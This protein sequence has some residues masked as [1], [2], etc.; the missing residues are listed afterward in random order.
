MR[1]I[2]TFLLFMAPLAAQDRP[3]LR[4][5]GRLALVF[6]PNQGQTDSKVKFLART[7]EGALFLTERE[8]VFASRG[9]A[10][11]RM[12]LAHAGKP[13]AIRGLEPT[14]GISNYFI[15][16][17]PAQWRTNIPQYGRVEYKSVYAGVDLVY[18][19][20]P[21]KLEY[22]FVVA[23]R[24]DAAAIQVEYEGV[25]S[26]RVDDAGD[27]V[28]KTA[29]G[30]LRQKRPVAYQE[31]ATGRVEVKVGY[32][33][34]PGRRVAFELA[35]YDSRRRL[36]IDPV[37]LYSSYLGGSA[38]D[39]AFGIAVDGSG[40][41]YVTG[42]TASTNFPTTNALQPS[43]AGANVA[44]V[45]KINATGSA[46]VYSTYL[47]GSGTDV[48]IGIAVDGTGAVY[49]TGS[50]QSTNFPTQLPLQATNGGGGDA[51][52][53]KMNNAGSVLLYS[54]YLGGSGADQGNGIAVDGTG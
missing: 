50:T 15:G 4:D 3:K 47:G 30:E 39:Q 37:L 48:G 9:A 49:V 10:P 36:V 43:N 16:N 46:L 1:R 6:E 18:Y 13:K 51:F 52:V 24:A 5:Y 28:L 32:R 38:L 2:A 8:A 27:L 33:M 14:G 23:P 17:D 25:E 45:T 44:F 53:T 11:V 21:Q 26:L 41:A 35:R 40:A 7:R 12:R 54:T 29:S 42:A 20:N 22:D 19:G 31:T 34:K